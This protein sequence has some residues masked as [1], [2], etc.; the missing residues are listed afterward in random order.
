VRRILE[1]EAH[2]LLADAPK[3]LEV[4]SRSGH[5][6][7]LQAASETTE[8]GLGNRHQKGGLVLEVAI[9]CGPRYTEP[10]ADLP[11]G[12]ARS[13]ALGDHGGG[14]CEKRGPEVPVMVRAFLVSH[15]SILIKSVD[16]VNILVYQCCRCQHSVLFAVGH[17]VRQG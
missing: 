11:H 9:G 17:R 4:G 14:F 10:P 16:T 12:Q 5:V 8:A 15:R 1:S 13:P 3:L 2:V 6:D 7:G